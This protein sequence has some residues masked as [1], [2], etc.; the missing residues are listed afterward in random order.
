MHLEWL[1][2]VLWSRWLQEM[3]ANSATFPL[4]SGP[5]NEASKHTLHRNL[6]IRGHT[7]AKQR[8]E[9]AKWEQLRWCHFSRILSHAK[10]W[11]MWK[12]GTSVLFNKMR[13]ILRLLSI[14]SSIVCF[15]LFLAIIFALLTFCGKSAG[16]TGNWLAWLLSHHRRC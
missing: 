13:N 10:V 15:G 4:Q 5:E 7:E 2:C 11:V 12:S 14:C 6:G 3:W 8:L 1:L 9:D 16:S